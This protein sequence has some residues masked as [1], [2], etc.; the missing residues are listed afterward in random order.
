MCVQTVKTFCPKKG[1]LT[2]HMFFRSSVLTEILKL[3]T[4]QSGA[5]KVGFYET[6]RLNFELPAVRLHSRF[7]H[8]G[9]R[10]FAVDLY[11]FSVTDFHDLMAL[12]TARGNPW[13]FKRPDLDWYV[14][15]PGMLVNVGIA[16]DQGFHEGGGL[17]FEFVGGPLAQLLQHS[18]NPKRVRF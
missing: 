17:Q 6:Y 2:N 3:P 13:F 7:R 8:C 18:H 10:W 5:W 9:G 15:P 1:A 16:K 11:N 4:S 12:V 14:L